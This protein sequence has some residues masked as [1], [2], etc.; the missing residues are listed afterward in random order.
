MRKLASISVIAV[1]A[2]TLSACGSSDWT[3]SQGYQDNCTSEPDIDPELQ[4]VVDAVEIPDDGHVQFTNVTTDSSNEGMVTVFF[5][6]CSPAE[7]DDLRAI[8]EDLA[9]EV[10]S[11]PIGST[12]SEMGVNA[13]FANPDGVENILRDSNF[14]MHLHDNGSARENGAYRAAWE[15]QN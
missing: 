1:A 12:V 3:D 8:A 10:K 13:S 9:V 2:L 11:N 5:A 14:Q 6:L 4:P 15:A 7:G